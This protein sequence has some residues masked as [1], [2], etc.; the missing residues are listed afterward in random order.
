MRIIQRLKS[1]EAELEHMQS[2]IYIYIYILNRMHQ[3]TSTIEK[4]G[5]TTVNSVVSLTWIRTH[6]VRYKYTYIYKSI[7]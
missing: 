3:N 2:G 7:Y 5:N 4:K 6:A 1:N